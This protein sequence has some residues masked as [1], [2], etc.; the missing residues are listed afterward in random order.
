MTKIVFD[1]SVLESDFYK[2]NRRSGI[3]QCTKEMF[4]T[5]YNNKLGEYSIYADIQS[6]HEVVCYF[7]KYYPEFSVFTNANSIAKAIQVVE[8]KLKNT[9]SKVKFSL[10]RKAFSLGIR[11]CRVLI[12]W[13]RSISPEFDAVLK[14]SDVFFSSMLAIPEFLKKYNLKCILLIHD[15]IPLK[16]E[17]YSGQLVGWFGDVCKSFNKRDYYFTNSEFTRKDLLELFGNSI[18]ENKVFNTYIGVSDSFRPV[19]DRNLFEKV[20]RKYGFTAEK[21]L[22]SLCNIEERKNLIMQAKAFIRFI[23]ENRI[24][25]LV[26]LMGGGAQHFHILEKELEKEIPAEMIKNIVFIGY[27]DDEDLPVLYSNAMWFTY[28]SK[29]EGFGLPPLEAMKCGCPVVTSNR[30]SLPEVC[31]DAAIIVD[32]D[33]EDEHVK[34]YK[35]MYFDD[36]LRN[37]Y[38]EKGMKQGQKFNWSIIASHMYELMSSVRNN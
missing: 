28:T 35:A 13:N 22:F 32:S 20:K 23:S 8:C 6:Y 19:K 1:A 33:S 29:Y 26:F 37:D 18:D 31:G 4:D 34:A 24:N 12:K 5:L 38:S 25:D 9:Q 16:M 2:D 36:D 7:K 21:Y 15:L 11:V 30:T 3:F 10:V 14:G 17:S 27:V